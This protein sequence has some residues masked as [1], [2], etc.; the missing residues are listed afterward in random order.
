MDPIEASEVVPGLRFRPE[1][2]VKLNYS[3]RI[4]EAEWER[5]AEA[6][7]H[8]HEQRKTR[9]EILETL[10][11][12]H[13]FCP[14]MA[15]LNMHMKKR[16]LR[17]YGGGGAEPVETAEDEVLQ[18]AD[19]VAGADDSS[20][21]TSLPA[22]QNNGA[23]ELQII[24]N[25]ERDL[26]TRNA[27]PLALPG[28]DQDREPRFPEW[29]AKASV[30]TPADYL[31]DLSPLNLDSI[32]PDDFE[33]S[34]YTTSLMPDTVALQSSRERELNTE[35][36]AGNI[37]ESSSDRNIARSE[38]VMDTE[39]AMVQL[40]P[41]NYVDSDQYA[42]SRAASIFSPISHQSGGSSLRAFRHFAVEVASGKQLQHKDSPESV[43]ALTIMSDDSW[44][45]NLV[46]G[47]RSEYHSPSSRQPSTDADLEAY[48][49]RIREYWSKNGPLWMNQFLQFRD[50]S[51]RFRES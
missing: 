38:A 5:H 16:K 35:E 13:E 7:K 40:D 10:H 39:K 22:G 50:E 51:N 14:S 12:D 15:Q 24:E 18:V 34:K 49:S 47:I 1:N 3:A 23:S 29:L 28:D 8:M 11:N 46:T 30:T 42:A 33:T 41:T 6:V 19:V 20:A 43:R 48:W 36:P 17:V 45:F 2:E 27:V 32:I 44:D 4:T 21:S 9:R 37:P 26:T 25:L 31:P